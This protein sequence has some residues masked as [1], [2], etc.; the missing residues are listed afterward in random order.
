MF[1][2]HFNIMLQIRY[3]FSHLPL[4]LAC[5][6]RTSVPYIVHKIQRFEEIS[7][8]LKLNTI[9]FFGDLEMWKNKGKIAYIL[10][11]CLFLCAL[12][13]KNHFKGEIGRL[14]DKG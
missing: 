5:C 9:P 6:F 1:L 11:S 13:D 10:D 14:G 8:M 4:H 7:N 12:P 3:L 2:K